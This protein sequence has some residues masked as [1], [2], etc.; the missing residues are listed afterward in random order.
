[1]KFVRLGTQ[2]KTGCKENKKTCKNTQKVHYEVHKNHIIK[3][4]SF[5]GLQLNWV[6]Q[7][8]VNSQHT[9]SNCSPVEIVVCC[10]Q[11]FRCGLLGAQRRV[12]GRVF[13]AELRTAAASCDGRFAGHSSD[14]LIVIRK[15]SGV[16]SMEQM[17]QLLPPD[18]III[19]LS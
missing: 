11:S 8:S 14:G 9:Y 4:T 12:F 18:S 3:S 19:L 1:M 7:C 16:A 2:I 6:D 17:E 5:D 10:E 13:L 15:L